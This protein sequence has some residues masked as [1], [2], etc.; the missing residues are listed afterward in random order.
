MKK[1]M[2][3]INKY[4]SSS[5]DR[6]IYIDLN[7][8]TEVVSKPDV[9]YLVNSQAGGSYH[10]KNDKETK[11]FLNQYFEFIDPQEPEQ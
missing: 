11:A 4:F 8:V 1:K 3:L 6:K 2:I 10:L 9:I 7:L 5:D